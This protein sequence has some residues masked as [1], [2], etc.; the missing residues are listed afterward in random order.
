M[1]IIII[2]I[3]IIIAIVIYKVSLKLLK[4]YWSLKVIL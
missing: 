1:I 4:I 3:I 2:I